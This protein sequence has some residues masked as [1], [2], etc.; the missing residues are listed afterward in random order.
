[1]QFQWS[2]RIIAKSVPETID[3]DI[4]NLGEVAGLYTLSRLSHKS[5]D[6]TWILEDTGFTTDVT[7]TRCRWCTCWSL[8]SDEPEI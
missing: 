4:L 8:V 6:F 7:C 3:I 2:Y 1:M 5:I